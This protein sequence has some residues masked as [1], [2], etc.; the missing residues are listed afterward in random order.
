M[1]K[2]LFFF[3]IGIF[4][5]SIS[6]A[7]ASDVNLVPLKRVVSYGQKAV[8][9]SGTE[10]QLVASSTPCSSLVVKALAANT[11]KIYVGSN[12]SVTT[13]NGFELNAQESVSLDV[14]NVQDVYIDAGVNGEGVSWIAVI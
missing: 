10:V 1:R 8:T 2:H 6:L 5:T 7:A 4:W 13:S 11:G 12:S 14:D 9:T 3:F